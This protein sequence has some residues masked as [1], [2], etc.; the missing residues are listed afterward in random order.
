MITIRFTKEGAM[1]RNH[2]TIR[3]L[4]DVPLFAGSPRRELELISR[5]FTTK[6]L[7]AG[8]VVIREGDFAREFLVIVEGSA[9]VSIDGEQI[10]ELH[11][12]DPV[13]EIALLDHGRRTATVTA[14]TDLVT[15]ICSVPDFAELLLGA[16][17]LTRR[18]LAGLAARL[19]AAD[20]NL[21]T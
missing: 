13:G 17:N 14:K 18:L 15:Q 5:K 9:T 8:D 21:A 7:D 3:R 20:C 16:P 1:R 6:Y 11:A 4:A 2:T 19:R 10:A 12:G